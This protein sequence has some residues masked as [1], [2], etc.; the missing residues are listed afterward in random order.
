[1][2]R[3]GWLAL[4]VAIVAA[5]LFR[6][7]LV[8]A[9]VTSKA[10]TPPAPESLL[11]PTSGDAPLLD[12]TVDE[13]EAPRLQMVSL[14][15]GAGDGARIEDDLLQPY[16]GCTPIEAQ[17]LSASGELTTASIAHL[18]DSSQNHLSPQTELPG[19]VM[20]SYLGF[21]NAQLM[22][23]NSQP[24]VDGV[25]DSV[26]TDPNYFASRGIHGA[27]IGG[28]GGGGGWPNGTS[29]QAPSQGSPSDGSPSDGSPSDGSTNPDTPSDVDPPAT[30]NPPAPSNPGDVIPP[31]E[32][33]PPVNDDSPVDTNPPVNPPGSTNP[34][35]DIIPPVN[36]DPPV[37]YDP[38]YDLPTNPEPPASVPEPGTFGLFGC[39]LLGLFL[40]RRRRS[41]AQ[42][43]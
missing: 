4:G 15:A 36:D 1:M 22:A 24:L 11:A 34:P 32:G 14:R 12:E 39:A 2:A 19:A 25:V 38:P 28:G 41:A 35:V 37:N 42:G 29:G 30:S 33:N 23:S 18:C 10:K 16:G 43:V 20:A 3:Y 5:I 7:S 26:S 40:A 8:D 31:A 9:Y 6:T 21:T 13:H 27:F 17:L